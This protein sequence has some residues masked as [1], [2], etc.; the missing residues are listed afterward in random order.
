MARKARDESDN[1]VILQMDTIKAGRPAIDFWK[2]CYEA[3]RPV[4]LTGFHGVGKSE[5]VEQTAAELGIGLIVLDLSLLEPP[6]L[7]GLPKLNGKTTVFVPPDFLPTSGRGIL[8]I[9]E[10]NRAPAHMQSPC[11]QLLTARKLNDYVLPPGW[12][13][14]GAVNPDGHDYDVSTLDPAL[15]SRFVEVTVIP[16]QQEWLKWA[17]RQ[18]LHQG[19]IDYVR[20]DESIFDHPQSNPRAWKYVSD[21]M[22]TA[23][24]DG[25]DAH[26]LRTAIIGVVGAKRGPA[27]L[28]SLKSVEHPLSAKVILTSYDIHRARVRRWVENGKLD[29]IFQS[30]LRLKK[31]LQSQSEFKSVRA[32]RSES[33]NMVRFLNDLPGDLRDDAQSF[34]RERGYPFPK[35]PA[36]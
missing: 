3:H 31:H 1:E 19:V 10:I 2:F 18:R 12:M 23:E 25:T 17:E 29:L 36:Q 4:L 21:L 7:I 13:P 16:D 35:R 33:K 8:F 22:L 26:V 32:N 24:R 14:G 20:S 27:F 28:K 5:I 6:D 9:E 30:L 11:M 34:F 15:R